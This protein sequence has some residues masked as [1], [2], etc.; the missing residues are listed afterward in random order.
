MEWFKNIVLCCSYQDKYVPFDSARIQICKQALDSRANEKVGNT[1]ITM[2]S[3]VFKHVDQK[4]IYRL[5]INF[6]ITDK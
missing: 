6:H 1:Y 3:N 2:A 4:L 5:D